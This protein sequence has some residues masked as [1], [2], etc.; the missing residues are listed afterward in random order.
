MASICA[1][2]SA[3]EVYLISTRS[4]GGGVGRAGGDRGRE[5]DD[6]HQLASRECP[7]LILP[8]PRAAF[9][10]LVGRGQ[11]LLQH[12]SFAFASAIAPPSWR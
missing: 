8:S 2:P 3:C 5:V 1:A 7:A 12:S 11:L 9:Q 10:A 4:N 6:P